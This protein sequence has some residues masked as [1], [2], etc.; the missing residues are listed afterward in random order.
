MGLIDL[1]VWVGTRRPPFEVADVLRLHWEEYCALYPVSREQKQAAEAIMVCRT[2]ALGGHI[3]VCAGCGLLRMSYNSCCNRNCPKCGAFERAQWLENRK[4]V[5]LPIEYF[6]VIFTVDHAINPLVRANQRVIYDLLFEAS[7]QVLKVYGR[8]YLGGELGATGVLQTWG[9]ALDLHL[10]T[11]WIV[12]GGALERLPDGRY[13]WQAAKPGYLFPVVALSRDYRDYVCD[14]LLKLWKEGKLHLM[15]ECAGLD[16]EALVSEMRSK[17]WEVYITPAHG[18]GEKK[19]EYIARYINSIAISNYRIVAIEDGRVSFKYHDNHDGGKEKIMT[20]DGVEFI[21]RFMLHVLPS[22]YVRVRHYGLHH[23]SKRK[24]LRRCR[25]L[26][27]LN[28]ELPVAAQLRL[29]DWLVNTVGVGEH[30][31]R[32]PRCGGMFAARAEFEPLT[33]VWLWAMLLIGLAVYGR[34]K[35]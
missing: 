19:F 13:R 16:V 18:E 26:L 21:R 35:V 28:S 4:P 17:A 10:H 12:T 25:A 5:L 14:G 1:F 23:S 22:R 27:G 11:H 32:C 20:V 9:E 34:V 6:H 2:A 24:D 7:H 8:K 29:V 31:N 3:D 30:P 15:G 33:P